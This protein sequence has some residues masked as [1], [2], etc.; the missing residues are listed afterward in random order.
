M[1]RLLAGAGLLILLIFLFLLLPAPR[2]AAPPP[3]PPP[4]NQTPPAPFNQTAA[5]EDHEAL[6]TLPIGSLEQGFIWVRPGEEIAVN[7]TFLARGEAPVVLNLSLERVD[8]VGSTTSLPMPAGL[9]ASVT[10]ATL[11]AAPGE[12]VQA[13][14]T[15]KNAPE[16]GRGGVLRI[17][18]DAGGAP[19]VADDWLRVLAS[20]S[21]KPGISG[22]Y[23]IRETFENES[24]VLSPGERVTTNCTVRA[25]E[26]GRL[27]TIWVRPFRSTRRSAQD[28]FPMPE[29]L[30]VTVDPSSLLVR[31]HGVYHLIVTVTAAEETPPGTYPITFA[32]GWRD[33]AYAYPS[34]EV[35]VR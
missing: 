23:H 12:R 17:A 11:R 14:V 35:T 6:T 26:G 8:G 19:V 28:F 31:N 10:P 3:L 21:P 1:R 9:S 20:E 16:G 34:I 30:T 22:V 24:L 5:L 33:R 25:G 2:V 29:G 27:D 18:A 7:Y 13:V 4:E 15:V 32:F